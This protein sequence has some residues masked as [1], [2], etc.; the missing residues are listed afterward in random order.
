MQPLFSD[1]FIS[2][3]LND[4]KLSSITN[5]RLARAI[6]KSLVEELNS[7]KLDTLKEEELKSRFVNSFFGDVLG[8]NYGNSNFWTLREE[9]KTK[10]DGTKPDAALG[11][12]SKNNN[13]NDVRVVIEIKDALTNLDE[14]QKRRDSKSP[15]SQAFEYS[16]KMG[17]KCKWVIVSNFKEIRFYS[18][19]FQG[20]YQLFLLKELLNESKLKE[21]LFFFH[22]DR[23][24]KRDLPSKTEQLYSLSCLNLQ[25]NEKPRHIIDEIYTSLKR[26]KGLNYV[27]PNY[28]ASIKPFNILEEY[29]WHY[30]NNNLFTI[31][32]K[33]HDLFKNLDFNDGV[34]IISEKLREELEKFEVLEFEEKIDYF[35]RFLNHS[36]VFEISCIEDY[37]RI[38]AKRSTS[39][40]F[41]HKH[42][43]HF[44]KNEGFTKKIDILK[45]K[46][47]DCVS[48]NFKSLD[49]KQLLSKLKIAKYDD[50]FQTLEFAYGNYL[51][52]TN[53]YK[54]S[55]NIYK[56]LSE[57]IKGKEGL[58]IEYFLTKLNMKYLLNLVWEDE[59][60]KDTFQIKKEI[61]N[62]DLNRILYDE[63]EYNIDDDVRNYLV[64]IKEE[65]LLNRSSDKIG[66][67]FN[68]ISD[69]K[70]LYDNGGVQHSGSNYFHEI[71]N[72]Y[73]H[74]QL[75]LNKNRIIYNVFH[76]YKLLTAKV[77]EGLLESYLTIDE[78]VHSFNSYY[79]IEFL[80]NINPSEFQKL[81][82]KVDSINLNKGCDEKIIRVIKNLFES[83]FEEG[84]FGKPYKNRIL[85]EYLLDLQFND[86]YTALI[87]NSFTLLSKINFSDNLFES[88][89][90]VIIDFLII[91]DDLVWYKLKEFGYLLNTKG[92]SFTSEQLI[93]ILEVAIKRDKPNNNKYEG[94]IKETC[95]TLN[96]F[97]PSVKI[98]DKKLVKNAIG[99]IDNYSKASYISYLL[100]VTN[101]ECQ[102]ILNKEFESMLDEEFDLY[103]YDQLIR[104]KMY[105]YK[106]KDFFT[107]MIS[108]INT[109]KGVG[110]NGDFVNGKPVFEDFH[111]Y[112]FV[113]LLNVL[114]IE[115]RNKIINHFS[116]LSEYEKWLINPKGY[117]YNFFDTN[118]VLASDNIYI[119]NNLRGIQEMIDVIE[120]KLKTNF[121]SKLS[122]IY[123]KY[124]VT[125]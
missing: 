37:R 53:N 86:R 80:I 2:H 4:F 99:N 89:S 67:L 72:Q 65:N 69:L 1:S 22:K 94:L 15:I 20:K 16:S 33:I 40:G 25:E 56:R 27:D 34:V 59:R 77:F 75:H 58:E 82:S 84:L 97:Y 60:L 71:A 52:S 118:W 116:N 51:V 93:R 102:E 100:I 11:Y 45:Y 66:E 44:S 103:F 36:Q 12:F 19:D 88:L 98:E 8:F 41:T 121:D 81:L 87:T 111:F 9:V 14:K 123:Y 42:H 57:K 31:N 18:S 35:I 54:E 21:L 108:K 85:E 29:V 38:I 6:I 32:P 76:K 17:D 107:K 13:E 68:S 90:K 30:S 47:C 106:K 124:L 105:S 91:E 117:N 122:E 62:I 119:H 110:F 109:Q 104:E 78:G 125:V 26:F 120:V 73:F 39:I 3:Y 101:S 70:K 24:I 64:K 23:F 96:K 61:R 95:K 115:N 49:F 79:L 114:C 43:F 74:L 10:I 112:N 7:G 113:I 5:I 55:Y 28:I 83:Y 92:A 46:K 63:I 50:E 48:C